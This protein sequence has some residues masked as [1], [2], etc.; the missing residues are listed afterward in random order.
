M[1]AGTDNVTELR[2]KP[3]APARQQAAPR[4]V[5]RLKFITD[6]FENLASHDL[7]NALVGVSWALDDGVTGR[8]E[9]HDLAVRGGLATAARIL[10]VQ[11]QNRL[12]TEPRRRGVR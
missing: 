8:D 9:L 1:S 10:A 11:L 12:E 2:A 7:V 4:H 6:E 5:E 3:Q